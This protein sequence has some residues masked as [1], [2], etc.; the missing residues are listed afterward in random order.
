MEKMSNKSSDEYKKL[1]SLEERVAIVTGAYGHL[2]TTISKALASFGANVILIG[3][4]EKKLKDF[5]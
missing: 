5:D 3:R 4:N 1:F 2:G